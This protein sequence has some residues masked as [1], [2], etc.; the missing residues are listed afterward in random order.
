MLRLEAEL[1]DPG[2]ET[3]CGL[4]DVDAAVGVVD[5]E[6]VLDALPTDGVEPEPEAP[7]F[8]LFFL[9][10]RDIRDRNALDFEVL[11][12]REAVSSCE[13]SEMTSDA[14]SPLA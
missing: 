10:N 8:F 5:F 13:S 7:S 14:S 11:D 12:V 6:L 4:A 2:G 9:P 3:A 1:T